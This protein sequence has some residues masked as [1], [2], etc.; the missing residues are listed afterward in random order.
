MF[1]PGDLVIY[2]G[3]GV[4]K[5]IAVATPEGAEGDK[6][7]YQ[8][9]PVYSAETIYAP[10]DTGV[11]M[12]AVISRREA[13]QLIAEI[14][15]IE[16]AAYSNHNLNLLKAHYEAS[17]QTHDCGDLM[18]LIKGVH[19]KNTEAAQ[20]RKKLGQVDQRYLKRAEELLYGELAAVLEIPR[21][22]VVDYIEAAAKAAEEQAE[23]ADRQGEKQ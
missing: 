1:S 23:P 14:P 9:C 20:H 16:G 11:F 4:C 8:L 21:D 22:Q 3:N 5:V 18:E 7:Y 2:G 17:M 13:E 15:G 12:R 19:H 10:V 6:L